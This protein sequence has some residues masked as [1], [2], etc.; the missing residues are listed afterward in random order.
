MMVLSRE[1][2]NAYLMSFLFTGLEEDTRRFQGNGAEP[3]GQE[4]EG[5]MMVVGWILGLVEDMF[6]CWL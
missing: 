4:R 1:N 2:G 3:D 5:Y 6:G